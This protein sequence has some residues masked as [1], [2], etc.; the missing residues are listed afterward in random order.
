MPI[1]EMLK[2]LRN[3]QK[4]RGQKAIEEKKASGIQYITRP[5]CIPCN[6]AIVDAKNNL[7]DLTND[8][9]TV[10]DMHRNRLHQKTIGNGITYTIEDIEARVNRD[11]CWTE[12]HLDRY[13]K[14]C[15]E[16]RLPE[17]EKFRC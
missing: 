8:I 10:R 3:Q 15:K 16:G 1:T 4:T 17:I 9:E 12:Y 11:K 2:K 13:Q 5:L 7:K 14:C 6:S